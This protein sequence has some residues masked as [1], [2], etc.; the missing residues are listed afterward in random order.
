MAMTD[1]LGVDVAIEAVGIPRTFE[2][3]TEIVR[4]A[5]RRERRRARQARSSC[6]LQDLWIMDIAI[7]TGLVSTTTTP[8]LLKLVAQGKLAAEK[9]VSHHFELDHDPRRLRH[10]RSR[11]RDEGAQGRD[12]SLIRRGCPGRPSRGSRSRAHLCEWFLPQLMRSGLRPLELA[13][14][15]RVLRRWWVPSLPFYTRAREGFRAHTSTC[16]T[17]RPPTSVNLAREG[18]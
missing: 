7:T 11:G 2:M 4:P 5:G 18:T 8:M 1:G 6:A 3:C 13:P 10:V 12:R 14:T 16:A 9:F 15:R 17:S